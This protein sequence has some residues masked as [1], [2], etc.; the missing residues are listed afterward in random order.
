ML[1]RRWMKWRRELCFN[2]HLE[3]ILKIMRSITGSTEG[4][5]G[6][7]SAT[8]SWTHSRISSIEWVNLTS[9]SSPTWRMY[10]FSPMRKTCK[11]MLPHCVSS[12]RTLSTRGKYSCR[13]TLNRL[14]TA[15]FWRQSFAM[16]S[17]KTESW[18]S[19]TNAWPS[20]SPARR[21][22]VICHRTSYFRCANTLSIRLKS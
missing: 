16:T 20:S 11:E 18:G 2:A 4:L 17:S 12:A 15:I 13:P 8:V 14:L 7:P 10:S 22:L 9:H 5:R 6:E 1:S 19:L 3:S 21:P